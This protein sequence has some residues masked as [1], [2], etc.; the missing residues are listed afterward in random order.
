MQPKE[1][2]LPISSQL[3]SARDQNV[4]SSSDKIGGVTSQLQIGKRVGSGA[5]GTVHI[6]HL[7]DNNDSEKRYIVK[8]AWTLSEIESNVPMAVMQLDSAIDTQRT[9]VAQ[10]TGVAQEGKLDADSSNEGDNDNS[11]SDKMKERA[12]RCRYYW[13]VERHIVQKLASSQI[14]SEEE[15]EEGYSNTHVTPQF[16]GVF[17]SAAVDD[18]DNSEAGEIVPGYGKIGGSDSTTENNIFSMI[19]GGDDYEELHEW[20]VFEYIPSSSDGGDEESLPALTLLDAMEVST[21]IL[22]LSLYLHL[23]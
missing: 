9:G 17:R 4:D 12:E 8:R 20:M 2:T 5:Y 18:N 21:R 7:L 22:Y 13:N 16:K 11:S 6:A 1:A 14:S 15:Q 23:S 10:A 3:Q 19:N